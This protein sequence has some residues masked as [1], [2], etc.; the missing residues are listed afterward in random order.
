[1]NVIETIL[2]SIANLMVETTSWIGFYEPK[3]PKELDK[4]E[5]VGSKN[6]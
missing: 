6:V 1:M 3:I 4:S 2:I 5:E